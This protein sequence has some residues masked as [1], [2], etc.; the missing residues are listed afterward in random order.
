MRVVLLLS[1]YWFFISFWGSLLKFRLS[2]WQ[3]SSWAFN[4]VLVCWNWSS[5]YR[6]CSSCSFKKISSY[7]ITFTFNSCFSYF[8]TKVPEFLL[9]LL[10]IDSFSS[11]DGS[12]HT[13]ISVI[14]SFHLFGSIDLSCL[15]A[16]HFPCCLKGVS[17][18][19]FVIFEFNY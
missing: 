18:A 19:A 1:I 6:R 13:L 4:W 5:F 3:R 2:F 17:W 8:I 9:Y 11:V 16:P 10:T 7:F 12:V 15:P 14:F